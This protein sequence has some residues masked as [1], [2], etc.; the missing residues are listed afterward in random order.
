MTALWQY[1]EEDVDDD[2]PDPEESLL[3]GACN[4]CHVRPATERHHCIIH[5]SKGWEAYLDVAENIEPVCHVC[6][7]TGVVNSTAH[8]AAFWKQQEARGYDMLG[9]WYSL[10]YKLTAG[11]ARPG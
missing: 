1:V 11:R 3:S 8:K 9:W 5:R 2:G 4:Y 6:H 7:M 10:P